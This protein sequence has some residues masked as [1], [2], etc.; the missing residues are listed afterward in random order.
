[1][2]KSV[3][4]CSGCEVTLELRLLPGPDLDAPLVMHE[5]VFARMDALGVAKQIKPSQMEKS[6]LPGRKFNERYRDEFNTE[7]YSFIEES[8]RG[9]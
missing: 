4:I 6:P 7:V 2:V 9:G 3:Q 8:G 5:R 1:M